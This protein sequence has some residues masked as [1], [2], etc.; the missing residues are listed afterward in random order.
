MSCF[1]H[2]FRILSLWPCFYSNQAIKWASG[3]NHP[4]LQFKE[5]TFIDHTW[6]YSY[7]D[8]SNAFIPS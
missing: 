6:I 3:Y 2:E 5:I 4:C 7:E 8:V 1:D